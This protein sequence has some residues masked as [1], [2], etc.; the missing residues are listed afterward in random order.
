MIDLGKLKQTLS[1]FKNNNFKLPQD[2]KYTQK[3]AYHMKMDDLNNIEYNE[4]NNLD[5]YLY[6]THKKQ[7]LQTRNIIDNDIIYNNGDVIPISDDLKVIFDNNFE[8]FYIYG[9]QNTES[10][11]TSLFFLINHNFIIKSNN[12][13]KASITSFKRDIGLKLDNIYKENKYSK[14]KF[15][16]SEMNNDIF[17]SSNINY[18]LLVLCCDY[19]KKNF[20]ILDK[21]KKSYLFLKSFH[22]ENNSFLLI[23]KF[24]NIYMPILNIDNNNELELELFEKNIKH[25][26]VKE[27][28][29]PYTERLSEVKENVNELKALSSYKVKDLQDL[30]K[31]KKIEI[32]KTQN[33]REKNKTKQELYNEILNF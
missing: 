27:N 12:E 28:I 15:I 32:K 14:F 4:N 1:N 23:V 16:K 25:N 21:N 17:N 18:P 8:K 6:K 26:F 7:I 29:D 31:E 9:I 5:E 11:F 33:G 19:L 10:F 22:S 20:C 30:A 24:N 3:T 13:K 2:I